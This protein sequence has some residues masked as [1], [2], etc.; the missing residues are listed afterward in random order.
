MKKFL[1]Y[2]ISSIVRPREEKLVWYIFW[3][4]VSTIFLGIILSFISGKL[5][6]K[7]FEYQEN[8]RLIDRYISNDNMVEAWSLLTGGWAPD[9][10]IRQ[11]SLYLFGVTKEQVYWKELATTTDGLRKQ[12]YVD[13]KFIVDIAN[14]KADHVNKEINILRI[15]EIRILILMLI[16]QLINALY[17][18]KLALIQDKE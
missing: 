9:D 6:Q 8:F 13:G 7:F 15:W 3:L 16:L 2:I 5:N 17:A 14:D 18:L 4:T 12:E 11:T 10:L 1:S